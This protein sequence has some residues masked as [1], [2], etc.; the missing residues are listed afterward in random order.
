MQPLT[1]ALPSLTLSDA[2]LDP[3]PGHEGASLLSLGPGPG[4]LTQHRFPFLP[5]GSRQGLGVCS[6][7]PHSCIA[8][9]WILAGP[10][11][12]TSEAG[13]VAASLASF[14]TRDRP[15]LAQNSSLERIWYF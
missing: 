11:L 8:S 15:T 1:G 12:K 2:D 5:V 9:C 14:T 7:G 4:P 13:P 6:M 3:A 10:L